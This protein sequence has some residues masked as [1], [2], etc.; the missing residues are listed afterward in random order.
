MYTQYKLSR[1]AA[2]I[3]RAC[4]FFGVSGSPAALRSG[5]AS[6]AHERQPLEQ[7]HVLLVL[8][9][10]AVERRDRPG[11]ILRLQDLE[12]HVLVEEQFQP[13]DQL[14]GRWLLLEAGHLADLVED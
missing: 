7:H 4:H 2:S 6:P 1:M 13:V 5:A 11:R 8:E 12:R 9:Q 3:K 10:G 14:A